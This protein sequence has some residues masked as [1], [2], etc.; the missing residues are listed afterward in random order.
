MDRFT[1]P[2]WYEEP[3]PEEENDPDYWDDVASEKADH[4]NKARRENEPVQ[5]DY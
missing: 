5:R 4:A 2:A 1:P 3:T